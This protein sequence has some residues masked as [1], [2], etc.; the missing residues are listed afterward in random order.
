MVE[1]AGRDCRS[2][3]HFVVQSVLACADE[4]NLFTKWWLWPQRCP[5]CISVLKTAYDQ[6][7][8]FFSQVLRRHVL[9]AVCFCGRGAC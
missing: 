1:I 3:M 9:G 4:F 8:F 2:F 5:R 7:Q 6:E